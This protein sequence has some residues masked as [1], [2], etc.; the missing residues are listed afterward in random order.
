MIVKTLLMLLRFPFSFLSRFHCSLKFLFGV[1]SVTMRHSTP[2]PRCAHV[3]FHEFVSHVI[4]VLETRPVVPEWCS[5]FDKIFSPDGKWTK[6][7]SETLGALFLCGD[8]TLFSASFCLFAKIA[9]GSFD[10]DIDFA[11]KY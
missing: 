10:E 8:C 4:A 9:I 2:S 1:V 11:W 7:P 6:R 3:Y 5:V